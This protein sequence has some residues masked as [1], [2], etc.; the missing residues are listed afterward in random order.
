MGSD[1]ARL[2]AKLFNFQLCRLLLLPLCGFRIGCL[3]FVEIRWTLLR[4]LQVSVL[5]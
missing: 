5:V 1:R 4:L 2:A 3:D